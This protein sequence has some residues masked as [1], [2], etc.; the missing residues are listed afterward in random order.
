MAY[1]QSTKTTM[2]SIFSTGL[3]GG[4][5]SG[6]IVDVIIQTRKAF[7]DSKISVYA[8]LPEMNLPKADMDQGR[9]YPNGYAA[10]NELNAL[11]AGRW[12]P[13]DVRRRKR[14]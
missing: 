8:M 1:I 4:T 7:P 14:Q 5:G 10:M 2:L 6:A 9:Y 3:S 12:C 11:Q 13:Q